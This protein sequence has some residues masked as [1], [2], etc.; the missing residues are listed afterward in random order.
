MRVMLVVTV[1]IAVLLILPLSFFLSHASV[2]PSKGRKPPQ[3]P[4]PPLTP[5]VVSSEL[6]PAMLDSYKLYPALFVCHGAGPL[7]VLGD[8]EHAGLAEKWREHVKHILA[9]Y[10]P[11]SVIAV[12][13]AHYNT[14]TP[15]VGG[16]LMPEMLYDYGG[17]PKESY[18][19][20]YAAPGQPEVARQ[21]VEALKAA[22]LDAQLDIRRPYDHGVFVPLLAMFPEARIPVVP[23]S[24]LTSDDPAEHIR[25][26]LALRPFRERGVFFL[27]SGSSMH[28]FH[29]FG[30]PGA[31][32]QFG[33]SL[34]EVLQG[35]PDNSPEKRLEA[36]R[37]VS[38]L[39][40]F[41]EAQP[42][43]AH[44]HLM[45]L[46][47]LL[48]TANGNAATAVGGNIDFLGASVRHYLFEEP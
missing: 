32:A 45:P 41:A 23:V 35:G 44:E 48:G 18:S 16:G 17:F 3:Q 12:V 31:G 34:T 9:K 20:R 37:H 14:A 11:P 28:H 10:G 43:G 6:P 39:A 46:L 47:T 4:L 8:P 1:L 19:L 24:V 2:G 27:G 21:M 15:C 25:M 22:G 36:M 26:G 5:T 29:N 30:K 42:R 7:P 38:R 13:S 40:G 33:D